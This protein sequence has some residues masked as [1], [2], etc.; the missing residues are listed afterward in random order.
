VQDREATGERAA[1]ATDPG[2]QFR[3]AAGIP[4]VPAMDGFRAFAILAI[5]LFHLAYYTLALNSPAARVLT[6]GTLPN[7]VDALF[8]VSGFVVFLPTVVRQGRFG[9]L[10]AYALRR[11]ARLLPAYWVA[12]VVVLVLIVL[13]PRSPAPALPSLP[14][15]GAH[16]AVLQMPALF[17]DQSFAIGLGIDGPLWTLSVEITFYLLLPLVAG[18]YFRHPLIGLAGA[19]LVTLAWKAGILYLNEIASL[20]GLSADGPTLALTRIAADG[21]FPAWAFSFGLG[22]TGAWAYVRLRARHGSER[23]ARW[24]LPAQIAALAGLAVSAYGI[25]LAALTNDSVIAH[26]LGRRDPAVS[27]LFSASLAA[28]MLATAL[29][30]RRLQWPFAIPVVR[31]L[32]DI[33]YGIYLIH[34]PVILLLVA[35]LFGVDEPALRFPLVLA[36]AIPVTVAYGWASARF[37]EGP[38]RR[39]AHRYGQRAQAEPTV[40]TD[41]GASPREAAGTGGER[42]RPLV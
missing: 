41:P 9:S 16:L 21:Q 12:L 17:V 38:I 35:L 5:V 31:S 11:G 1:T 10:R 8:I 6:W 39:W 34:L 14:E 32:G 23:L 3:A 19:A 20:L 4:I 22:M 40:G 37:L 26:S 28:F 2:K 13:W 36:T 18:L 42:D 24:A 29:G 15:V 27:M 25:G 30:S 7:L 33:S